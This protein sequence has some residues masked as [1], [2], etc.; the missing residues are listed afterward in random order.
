MKPFALACL[1]AWLGLI[2]SAFAVPGDEHWDNRFG[3]SGTTNFVYSITPHNGALFVSGF[4]GTANTNASIS[5]WD[6]VNWT[7]FSNFKGATI[8]DIKFV[9]ETMYVGGYFTNVDGAPIKALT[10]YDG[11]NWTDMGFTGGTVTSLAVDGNDLYVGGVF[12]NVAVGATNVARW[13]GTN[14]YALGAGIGK[15]GDVVRCLLRTNG[16]LYASGNFTNS[17]A[18]PL[19]NVAVWNGTSWSSVGPGLGVAGSTYV[20]GL[21]Q[22]G[23]ELY[24]CGLFTSA[25]GIYR[26]DGVNWTSLGTTTLSGGYP[27]S[28]AVLNDTLCVAG[29]FTNISTLAASRL[30]LWN[31]SSW[32]AAG[33]GTSSTIGR[34]ASD[35]L[36]AYV[37]GN[38]L[39]AGGMLAPGFAAWDGTN[40][41]PVGNSATSQ[42]ASAPTIRCFAKSGNTLYTGG[43]TFS[44]IGTAIANRIA[45]FDGANWSPLSAGLNGNVTSLATTT[46]RIYASGDFTGSTGVSANHL[47]QWD[48]TNWAS[49]GNSSLTTINKIITRG[50]DLFVAGYFSF[51][52][53]DG[54]C[55]WLTRWDGTNFWNVPF[56]F[57]QYTLSQYSLDGVGYSAF[58]MQGSNIWVSGHFNISFCDDQLNCTNC[59]EVLWFDG[60]TAR[61]MGS[62]L[63]TNA[64]SIAAVGTNVYFAGPFISA[65]G[66][67][68]SKI[69]RWDGQAWWPL[70]SGLVGNGVINALAA[71]GGNLYAGGTFTNMGGVTALRVAK[72]DGTSWSALGSGISTPGVS[73]ATVSTLFASGSDLY[74]GGTFRASGGKGA[75]Y[76]AHWNETRNFDIPQTILLRKLLSSP[77]FGFKFDIVT[78]EIPS[79]VIEGSTDFS[80]WTPLETNT[81]SFYEFW[82]NDTSR[83]KRFYRVRGQP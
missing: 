24:A 19:L 63:S 45:S 81:A 75:Y 82:D 26:W 42:G 13:D 47:A 56:N 71:S 20:Y 9:G 69:A 41:S 70:G 49:V 39:L 72:W 44:A 55:Q 51:T 64:T 27:I 61:L 80:T 40:W 76:I 48:G 28:F 5:R 16:L 59:N 1:T 25:G 52:A 62:G 23:T 38:F 73:S 14:W 18:I 79:Y 65:G 66:V 6:G 58:E 77:G 17:G 12:T 4:D 83:T 50:D 35:G 67:A 68:V 32:S 11:T 74:A 2:T 78:T 8:Y 60:T 53:A 10:R 37:G 3:W 22:R 15:S 30:A 34:V 57:P 46:S 31:G 29:S 36:R 7:N 33:S 21:A 43:T 54:S